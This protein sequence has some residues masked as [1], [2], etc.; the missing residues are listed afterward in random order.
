VFPFAFFVTCPLDAL[1]SEAVERWVAASAIHRRFDE[2]HTQLHSLGSG[3][4]FYRFYQK[5][6]MP[7]RPDDLAERVGSLRGEAATIAADSWLKAVAFDGKIA[8]ATWLAGLCRRVE[9]WQTQPAALADLAISCPL[10]RGYS[11]EVQVVLWLEW[12]DGLFKKVAKTPWLVVPMETAPA[13]PAL[14]LVV[15]DLLPDDYQLLTTDDGKYDFAERLSSPPA[16]DS[17]AAVLPADELPTGSLL[18]WLRGRAA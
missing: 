9:R 16:T 7:L 17:D 4:D 10:A 1:G 6:T 2:F 12:L 5:H 15:R 11:N 14:H 13:A 8:P 18:A 3:G